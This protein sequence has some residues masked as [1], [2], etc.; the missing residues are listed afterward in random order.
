MLY[1]ALDRRLKVRLNFCKAVVFFL[2]EFKPQTLML[3]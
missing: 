2:A 1:P 3:S